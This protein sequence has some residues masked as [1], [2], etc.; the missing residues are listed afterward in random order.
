MSYSRPTLAELARRAEGELSL[1]DDQTLRRNLF[2]PLARAISAQ[3]H[4]LYGYGQWIKNQIHPQHCDDDTLERVHAPIWLN[5]GRKAAAAARGQIQVHGNPGAEIEQGTLYAR[6]DRVEYAVPTGVVLP[7]SGTAAISI[8]C[9]TPGQAGNTEPGATLRLT[10]PLPGV[11]LEASVLAPGLTEGADDEDIETLRTRVLEARRNGGQVG[12]PWDWEAWAK[13]VPGVTRAW[14]APQL[15]GRGT[16]TVF[17]VRDDE[18]DIYPDTN[19]RATVQAHLE[20]TGL[21]FGEVFAIAPIRKQ[22]ALTIGISPDTPEVRA[23]ARDALARVFA[24]T[25]SPVARD[26]NGRTL[27]PVTGITILRSHLTQALSGAVGEQ[28]HTLLGGDIVCEIG[29]LAELG[30]ITWI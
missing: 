27:R 13:E 17:F 5:G 30:E 12:R 21:P 1:S 2:I 10:S 6:L 14:C 9:L 28:D 11:T 24:R 20:A 4:G 16:V 3:T 29:E 15:A 22:V 19:E 18:P 25:A 7:E 23:A 26:A 8:V